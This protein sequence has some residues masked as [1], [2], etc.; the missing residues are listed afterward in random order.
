MHEYMN[1]A[2]AQ[3]L[4]VIELNGANHINKVKNV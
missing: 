1:I 4:H 3:L 2:T